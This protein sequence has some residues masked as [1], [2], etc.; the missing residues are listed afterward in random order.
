MKVKLESAMCAEKDLRH[1]C[2]DL[3]Q[4]KE[5]LNVKLDQAE[6]QN[7]WYEDGHGLTESV[8]YQTKLEAGIRRQD[9]DLKSLTT[10]LG[11]YI[12]KCKVLEKALEGMKEKVEMA[13]FQVNFSFDGKEI[14]DALKCKESGLKMQNAELLQ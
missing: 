9:H 8:Q 5:E 12:D 11:K 3:E 7:S 6:E 13:G 10:E 1:R 14:R 4:Q 2:S